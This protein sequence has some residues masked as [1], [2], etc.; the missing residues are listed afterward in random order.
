MH[1]SRKFFL[2]AASPF[3]LNLRLAEITNDGAAHASA[4]YL[5]ASDALMNI[6][7][8]RIN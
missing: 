3:D 7:I 8:W 5:Q 6:S 1:M 4:S 2:S